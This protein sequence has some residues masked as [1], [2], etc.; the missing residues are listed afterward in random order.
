MSLNNNIIIELREQD[1]DVNYASGDYSISLKDSIPLMP[2]DVVEIKS[3]AIDSIEA[4]Q[5]DITLEEDTE[6]SVSFA[7]YITNWNADN[8]PAKANAGL[9]T[10]DQP[11][12]QPYFACKKVV[13]PNMAGIFAIAEI[14]IYRENPNVNGGKFGRDPNESPLLL[15]FKY[16]DPTNNNQFSNVKFN[17]PQQSGATDKLILNHT[18]NPNELPIFLD[19]SSADVTREN[20]PPIFC[21]N[22]SDI[23]PEDNI[24]T[25]SV[26]GR[27]RPGF[28]RGDKIF[29]NMYEGSDMKVITQFTVLG[30]VGVPGDDPTYGNNAKFTVQVKNWKTGLME[31]KVVTIAGS[32]STSPQTI[33]LQPPID[34]LN[35]AV[36]VDQPQT[37]GSGTVKY[38]SPS[39]LGL[40]DGANFLNDSPYNLVTVY[41][42][43]DGSY[44]YNFFMN[45]MHIVAANIDTVANILVNTE[46][47][48]IPEG[49]YP[50][51]EICEIL[52]DKMTSLTLNGNSFQTYPANNKFLLTNNQIRGINN[53]ANADQQ[54]YVRFDGQ[55]FFTFGQLTANTD[56]FIGTTQ[57]SFIND[58][59]INKIKIDAI[60]MS[61]LDTTTGNNITKYQQRG[62][63]AN[64]GPF[65]LIGRNGGIVFTDMQPQSFFEKIGFSY[66][67]DH[68]IFSHVGT[69]T[70]TIG[71]TTFQTQTLPVDI[72]R[73]TTTA[74]SGLD[75]ARLKA[76]PY[77]FTGLSA[78]NTGG[79]VQANKSILALNSIAQSSDNDG[80]FQIEVSGIPTSSV[81]SKDKSNDRIHSIISRYFSS[82]SYT[83]AYNEGSQPIIYEG[84]PTMISNL[85][86][87]ILNSKGELSNDV[88]DKSTIFL[89][90]QRANQNI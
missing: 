11:D 86:V 45:N 31:Q 13:A 16:K 89:E 73:F 61:L 80:F 34:C 27:N 78:L 57:V 87:R 50:V 68:K 14:I 74:D 69:N 75:T 71:G 67:D 84:E 76:N 88:N 39:Q 65:E 63:S 77:I 82:G 38:I 9:T 19:G 15:N 49:K 54:H 6:I 32:F 85:R 62:P 30:H 55:S 60:H 23:R 53:L 21:T 10:Q 17:I 7:N 47:F 48:T 33:N 25:G 12:L 46:T 3:V 5:G 83:T 40:P 64:N 44:N 18:T 59:N 66:D 52:T 28:G 70:V 79:S 51:S 24:N 37:D 22:V 2:Q 81:V 42:N 29:N 72:G 41:E 20:D 26:D 36:G 8:V 35:G 43:S 58:E 90:I 56:P 4:N 1:A